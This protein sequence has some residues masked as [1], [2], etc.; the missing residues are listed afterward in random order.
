MSDGQDE[1][2]RNISDTALWVAAYRAEESERPDALFHDPFAR[3]LT[4]ERGFR[5]LDA[6][7]R[8][9]QLAWPMVVRTALVDQIVLDRVGDGLDLVLDLAAGLD[10]RPYRMPLPPELLWV[11]ADLP[12]MIAAKRAVLD[13]ETPVCRLERFPV[14]LADRGARRDLLAEIA[15]RGSR[16]LVITEGL[17]VYLGEDEVAALARDLAAAGSCR[18]W[19][20]DLASPGLLRYMLRSWG[21]QVGGAGA[22]FR[23]APAAGP[24]FF[25]ELGWRPVEVHNSFYAAARMKRLPW[26]YA[27]LA[28]L[29][30][31]RNDWKPDRVWGGVCLFE[32][33]PAAG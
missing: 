1:Q 16:G 4:G 18:W 31:E 25:R 24:E 6:M 22:P 10:A 30:R 13:T 27:L 23:F 28:R 11:E 29:F 9:R 14:D 15:G 21:R 2:L 19:A 26:F 8:G 17:L 32:R 3:R 33:D 7:P 12:G 5:L 20:T